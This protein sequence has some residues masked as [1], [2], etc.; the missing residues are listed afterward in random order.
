MVINVH[1]GHNPDGKTACGAVGLIKESTEARKVKDEVISMLQKLGH[2][3]YDCTCDNGTSQSDV[4][5]KIVSKCKE[6]QADLDVSI[7]FNAGVGDKTGNG[8]TTGTEVLVYTNSP[9]KNYADGIVKAI[10]AL[11]YKN[12]G[13]K[14]R[15]DLYFLKNAKNALL[16][17]A[18]FV[19]DADDVRLYSTT[20]M[21]QAIVKGIIGVD[22]GCRVTPSTPVATPAPA[23]APT[24]TS[25]S[26]FRVKVIVPELNIRAGAGTGF[27]LNGCITN[28][29]V[30]TI[31]STVGSW[32]KLKSGAGWINISS[33]YCQRV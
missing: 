6:H 33:R 26:E 32:G 28:K 30:Y 13:V 5:R 25:K 15:T 31:V 4:L 19:D 3:V 22:S 12:R 21:A 1:A 16:I 20:A 18:C 17:E 23:P 9:V 14:T 7:H 2:T 27:K 10:A 24:T 29:G 8:V 11:G